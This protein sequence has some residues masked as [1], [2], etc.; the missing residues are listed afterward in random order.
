MV[1]VGDLWRLWLNHSSE[2][3]P[4]PYT[5]WPAGSLA[6]TLT[7][8]SLETKFN[9]SSEFFCKIPTDKVKL[10]KSL[11]LLLTWWLDIQPARAFNLPAEEKVLQTGCVGSK[12]VGKGRPLEVRRQRGELSLRNNISQR[13]KAY[14]NIK[15]WIKRGQWGNSIYTSLLT[16]YLTSRYSHWVGTSGI[17]N[18]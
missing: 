16:E 10:S 6:L 18:A 17:S 7:Q 3:A 1:E 2:R 12:N 5:S 15:S 4:P 14:L 8:W 11:H 13:I 9:M